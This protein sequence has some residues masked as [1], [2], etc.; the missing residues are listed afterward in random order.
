MKRILITGGTRGLG[1]AL[2][3]NLLKDGH[4]VLAASKKPSPEFNELQAQFPDR[5]SFQAVDLADTASITAFSRDARLID[6]LDGFVAN[7]AVGLAGVLTLTQAA[8]IERAI[9]VNV[10]G[11]I[12]LTREALKGMLDRGGSVVFVSS[13]AAKTGL[14]GLSVYSATKGALLAFSRSLAREY[15]PRNIRVNCV[16]PGY[17]QSEMSAG[18]EDAARESVLRRTPLGRLSEA[19]DVVEAIRFLLSDDSASVT[20]T[21]LVVDAG[22]SA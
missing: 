16:L 14:T 3:R 15:G 6:G 18:M 17:F 19:Q 20:G 12:L 13:V 11:N 1:L 5:L 9:N 7:A 4:Q 8:E 2:S 10:L 22:F 21:E